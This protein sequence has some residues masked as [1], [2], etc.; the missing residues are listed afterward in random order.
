M[1][2]IAH[3]TT[4]VADAQARLI[5]Q[6]QDR[7]RLA[8]MI[9]AFTNG[10]QVLEDAAW[11]VLVASALPNAY[12]A[13]LGQIGKLV[14]QA[15]NGQDDEDYRAFIGARIKTNR[16]HGKITEL[17]AIGSLLFGDGTQI[18]AHVYRPSA[19]VISVDGVIINPFVAWRDFLNL[20][21]GAAKNLDLVYSVAPRAGSLRYGTFYG[22]VPGRVAGNK[23]GS[24]YASSSGVA[25]GVFG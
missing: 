13:T 4:H 10:F 21:K 22:T 20:A 9:A 11:A 24:V 23:Q 19:I 12:G 16:S 14:G 8:A 25:A 3:V 7:P 1:S 6:Y 18:R 5:G 15:C 17:L 2:E